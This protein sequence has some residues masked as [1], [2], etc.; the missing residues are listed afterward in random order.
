MIRL[1]I[2]DVDGTLVDSQY[3]ISANMEKAFASLEQVWPGHE[4]TRQ[5]IG[6]SLLDTMQRLAPKASPQTHRALVAAYKQVAYGA[7]STEN[8]PPVAFFPGAIETVR[9]LMARENVL[10]GLATGKS[11]RGVERLLKQ[12]GL[13]RRDFVSIQTADD[14]PSKPNPAMVLNVMAQAGGLEG[15]DT[16][17]VGDTSYDMEMALAAGAFALGVGWG[18]HDPAVLRRSGAFEILNKF[19]D[20]DD[21]LKDLW[22]L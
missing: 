9:G 1:V 7:L 19:S 16:L 2:F 17:V 3:D 12:A 14:A 11:Q 13:Q 18:Y 6:L 10:V 4:Q 22:K 8:Q 15:K 21:V 20:L 5:C